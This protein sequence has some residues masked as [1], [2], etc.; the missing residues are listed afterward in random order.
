LQSYRDEFDILKMNKFNTPAVPGTVLRKPDKGDE[1]LTPAKQTQYHSGVGKGMHMMQY[2]R[3]DTYNAVRDLARHMTKATQVHFDAMLRLMKYVDDTSDRGMVLN[4]TRK[5]DGNKEH[6]FIISDRSDSD[7]AKDTQTQKSIS[8]YRVLL[9]GAPVTVMFKSSTQ[10]SVALSVCEAEPE[11]TAGVLC[12]Q[13]MLYVWHI[14][15]SMGLKVKLLMILEMDNKGA[16][17]LANNWSI[18]VCTRHV[19]V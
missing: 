19:D 7:Y 5:W 11:Q 17:D 9:E 10:K 13:D 6:E 18:G 3:P 4:P 8:G 2:S 14:L 16:V 12:A 15:E 1:L